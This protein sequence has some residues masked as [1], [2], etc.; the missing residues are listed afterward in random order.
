MTSSRRNGIAVRSTFTPASRESRPRLLARLLLPV[1]TGF[2]LGLH[3][4]A[5][6]EPTHQTGSTAAE[7]A[8]TATAPS[9]QVAPREILSQSFTTL[10]AD[11]LPER[12]TVTTD[13]WKAGTVIDEATDARWLEL[14]HEKDAGAA[15]GTVLTWIDATPLRGTR[16]ELRSRMRTIGDGRGQMW[17][18]VD[19]KSRAMGAFDNM[20]DRP[21]LAGAWQDVVIEADVAP[22]AVGIVF[23]WMSIAGRATIQIDDVE[24]RVLS[25]ALVREMQPSTPALALSDRALRNLEAAT[26]LFGYLR[27]FHPSDE[28]TGVIGWDLVALELIEAAAPAVDDADLAARLA[29]FVAPLAPTMQIWT[30][31]DENAPP[32]P[33]LPTG[34]TH[35]RTIVHNGVGGLAG[36]HAASPY[37]STVKDERLAAPLDEARRSASLLTKR[38]VD[39]V[40]CRVPVEVFASDGGTLP[41]GETPARFAGTAPRMELVATNR[42]TRLA[43][44]VLAWTVFQHFYPY[45]DVVECDWDAALVDALRAASEDEDEREYR[46]TLAR[47]VAQ[48]HDGHG[49]VYHQSLS[50]AWMLPISLTWADESVVIEGLVKTT[51]GSAAQVKEL[52]TPG[53]TILAIDGEPIEALLAERGRL[54][55]AATEGWRRHVALNRV[56]GRANGDAV[57]LRVRRL[58]GSEHDVRL[59]PVAVASVASTQP[60]TTPPDG[61]EIADGIV[62]FSLDGTDVAAFEAALPALTAARGIIFDLRGYPAGAAMRA[63]GHL[64]AGPATSAQWRIPIA[65]RPDR[66]GLEWNISGRWELE[67]TAPRFDVPIAFLTDASAISYAESIMGIVEHYTLGEIVGSTTAGTNGNVNPFLLP[68]GYRVAWTGMQVLK[69]DG[70]RHHGVG[71]APTVPVEPTRQGIAAGRDEVLEKGV[72]VVQRAIAERG[73]SDSPKD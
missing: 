44:V 70:S 40:M 38:L 20:D 63:L 5:G 57:L 4:A 37:H 43:G 46:D 66:E 18:R 71:I 3:P 58:D 15:F 9:D 55:S 33:S 34:A 35:V 50:P 14:V 68:G 51:D 69:H 65:T 27:F 32:L 1:I 67:P 59:L 8:S 61:S 56:V 48:L 21:V 39:G 29:A 30:G 17:L 47:L 52:L 16:I 11:A 25:E 31:G 22:D 19:R 73:V 45:F 54:I 53:D 2:A 41:H 49:G 26:R 6:A 10:S 64:I 60:S 42:S 24:L 36:A 23:G 13:G 62:Y 72:E 28:V 7:T 12:W